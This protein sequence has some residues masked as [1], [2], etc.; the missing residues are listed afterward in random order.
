MLEP[1]MVAK[2]HEWLRLPDGTRPMMLPCFGMWEYTHF[3]PDGM[4]DSGVVVRDPKGCPNCHGSFEVPKD[5]DPL[6]ALEIVRKM[7]YVGTVTINEHDCSVALRRPWMSIAPPP[8]MTG[9]N[10]TEAVYR[11]LDAAREEARDA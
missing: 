4:T 7:G 1:A 9:A 5:E 8:P 6:A 3:G 11:A 2:V 10:I